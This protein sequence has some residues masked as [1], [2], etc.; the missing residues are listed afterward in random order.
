MYH[1]SRTDQAALAEAARVRRGR[2]VEAPLVVALAVLPVNETF[3]RLR[4]PRACNTRVNVRSRR[5]RC[6]ALRTSAARCGAARSVLF[7]ATCRN[8]PQYAATYRNMPH[9]RGPVLVVTLI[10]CDQTVGW[11]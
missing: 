11:I 6:I 8:M 5:M 7:T 3:R 4:D 2:E 1:R 10:Y 9:I